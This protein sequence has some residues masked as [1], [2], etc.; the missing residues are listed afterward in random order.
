MAVAVVR[1]ILRRPEAQFV[2]VGLALFALHRAVAPRAPSR[3]IE[4][5]P[6]VREAL[7]QDHRRR[8]GAEPTAAELEALVRR[9]VETEVLAREAVS[10]GL[11]RGDTIVRR[12]LVQKMELLLEAEADARPPTEAELRALAARRAEADTLPARRSFTHVFV[13]RDRHPDPAAEAARL[14]GLLD[15]GADPATLGDPFLRGRS[16]TLADE[17]E[18]AGVFGEPF[19]RAL[20]AL[21][22]NS[23]WSAPIA[24]SYGL[25]LVRV[26]ERRPPEAP[27]FEAIRARL[28]RAF[29]EERRA[30]ARRQGLARLLARYD[31]RVAP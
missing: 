16:L 21:D 28:R 3:R 11:D 27:P 7:A 2:V 14:R 1:R 6:A 24:S 25:H 9:Y 10:L 5:G 26:T 22:E 4:V 31:V 23:S 15:G 8:S 30:E 13:S 20:F 18:A 19:A 17:R 29:E 12:R